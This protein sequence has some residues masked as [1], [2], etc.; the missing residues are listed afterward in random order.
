MN[1]IK[2][3]KKSIIYLF[4]TAIV[5]SVFAI[6]QTASADLCDELAESTGG[7]FTCGEEEATTFTQFSGGLQPPSEE[8]YDP[9]LT[10][11]TNLRD[12]VVNVVNFILGFL[13][14][15][16]VIMIIYG[17]FMYVT[18]GG[19]E[20]QT[21]KGKKSIMYAIIGIVVILISFALVNTVIRGLG[22]G[23]DVGID[24]ELSGAAEELTGEQTQAV[25]RLFF[26]AAAQV[27]RAAKDLANAY[28]HYKDV[29]DALADLESV[30]SVASASQLNIYLSDV[31]R[32]LRN[33]YLLRV[34]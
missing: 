20:E 18:A 7:F 24:G 22:K 30:P 1:S 3:L 9:S 8:G 6:P 13:G 2:K 15:V 25:Q 23:T 12:Y 32:A 17:G 4:F 26:F 31:K 16:A 19:Q 11:E 29:D 33:I 34:S 10:Q 5:L 28:A 14:L 21:T 27:E